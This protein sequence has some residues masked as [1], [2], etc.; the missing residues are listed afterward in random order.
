MTQQSDEL[1][2]H[3]ADAR[4]LMAEYAAIDKTGGRNQR[5]ARLKLAEI[6]KVL[7]RYNILSEL[8]LG[9]RLASRHIRTPGDA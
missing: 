9:W 2:R 4:R 7:D 6:D 3:E 8:E 5:A 1:E